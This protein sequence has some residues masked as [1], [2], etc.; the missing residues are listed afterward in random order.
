MDLIKIN[1]ENE[2]KKVIEYLLNKQAHN[3]GFIR[4]S[5][6]KK[7]IVYISKIKSLYQIRKIFLHLVENKIFIKKSL[8]VGYNHSS[9]IISKILSLGDEAYWGYRKRYGC[10]DLTTYV[11]WD[12]FIKS[13]VHNRKEEI[14][15]NFKEKI[16][17]ISLPSMKLIDV[18]DAEL[19]IYVFSST[20]TSSSVY[21]E[22]K[23]YGKY[24]Y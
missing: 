9:L 3:L 1:V 19:D 24:F 15:N 22:I 21:I 4:Y 16:D 6:F 7:M 5:Q 14:I 10:N 18:D 11:M 2:S 12:Y 13:L 17:Y 23:G 20:N 8:E